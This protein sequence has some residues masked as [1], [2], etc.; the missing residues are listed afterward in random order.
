V[1]SLRA[2]LARKRP[3]TAGYRKAMVRLGR[4]QVRAAARRRNL[5]SYLVARL[6]GNYDRIAVENL[7]TG[8]LAAARPSISD[9]GWGL[10]RRLLLKKA[11]A[12]GRVVT[13][14][15]AAYNSQ[16]C[17]VCGGRNRRR[18]PLDERTF[19]C[20]SCGRRSDRDANAALVVL[21]RAQAIWEGA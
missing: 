8:R 5:V 3:G 15:P 17:G 18:L 2:G 10:F 9:A 1:A 7:A 13:F 21:H 12:A 4:A 16:T 19:V 14:V 20:E 6:V 11:E